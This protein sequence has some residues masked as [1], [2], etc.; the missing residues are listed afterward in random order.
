MSNATAVPRRSISLG[1]LE[2]SVGT[3]LG[4][5]DWIT[6]DQKRIDAFAEVSGDVQFIHVDPA[7]AAAETPFGGT[8]AHGF[9]VLSLIS[10]MRHGVVPPIEDL[11]M[12]IN[13]GFDRVRFTSPVK[14]GTR[15]RGHVTMKALEHHSERDVQLTW[16]ITVEIEHEDKPALVADWLTR[17]V[18]KSGG[19]R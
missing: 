6:I 7:R 11:A 17:A 4:T 10:E 15:I 13:Y 18:L 12:G 9:L 1:E 5:S 2:A 14:A 3:V 16:G 19:D 8:I